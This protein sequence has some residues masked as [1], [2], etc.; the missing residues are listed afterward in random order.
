MIQ[1]SK[2]P[3]IAA[4]AALLLVAGCGGGSVSVGPAPDSGGSTPAATRVE[5]LATSTRGLGN[6]VYKD[7]AAWVSMSNSTTG[8]SAVMKTP[9]P[10]QASSRWTEVPLG[11][12]ALPKSDSEA[13][14]RTPALRALGSTLWL[15]Q[16]AQESRQGQ[17]GEHGLC[18]LDASG[19]FAARDQP[20]EYCL[21]GWCA[22]LAMND[23]K[24]SNGRLYSNAGAG[25]NLFVSGDAAASWRVVLGQFD[26]MICTHQA[27][28]IVGERLLVGG[29]CPLDFAYIRAYQLGADGMLASKD[30]LPVT[31]PTLENRNVQFIQQVA[32]SQRVFAGVEGGLLRSEDGGQSF[33]FVIQQPL[34]GS[35]GYPYIRHFLALSGKP[36]TM[37]AGGFDKAK[38]LPYLAWS[39]DGGTTWTDISSLLPGYA[40]AA[41]DTAFAEVSSVSEDPQGRVIV[42]VNLK[43]GSE[44]RVLLLTLVKS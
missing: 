35:T 6:L 27:F 33:K 16:A 37:V 2:G 30:A 22:P 19:A 38:A 40:R 15:F 13:T 7:G 34:V 8:G 4:A 41:G 43:N 42:T 31:L 18:A 26:S 10:L 32:G 17:A 39:A 1:K 9:L 24:L 44:G 12:C 20:L 14:A 25:Q 3:A 5:V 21:G 23:L 29:E 11:A 28:Q 36:E